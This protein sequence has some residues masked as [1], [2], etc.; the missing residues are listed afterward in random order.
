MKKYSWLKDSIIQIIFISFAV[1]FTVF[2]AQISLS[3]QYIDYYESKVEAKAQSLVHS[4][5]LLFTENTDIRNAAGISAVLDMIFASEDEDNL[6]IISYTL[7]EP[8]GR[9]TASNTANAPNLPED[10][11]RAVFR[12]H[13]AYTYSEASLA[14]SF[15]PMVIEGSVRFI[16]MVQIDDAPF[17][18]YSEELTGNLYSSLIRGTLMMAVGYMFFSVITN[19]RKNKK[20]KSEAVESVSAKSADDAIDGKKT[21]RDLQKIKEARLQMLVQCISL[22]IFAALAL[23]ALHINNTS[24]GFINTIAL[25]AA[26]LFSA[27][28][29]LHI[30]RIL[31]WVFAWYSKRPISSYAAQTM[32]FF[33]FLVV[34]LTM[35]VYTIQSGYST[36][37]DL[38][39]Q[40]ELRISSTFS[41][42]SLSGKDDI[43][44]V[45][46]Q[47]LG[48]DAGENN[49]L[50]IIT[51]TGDSF[52]VLGDETKQ[53]PEAN[54]LF[55]S[56]WEGQMSVTG[57]R[58]DYKYGITF[59]ADSDFNISALAAVRQ[60]DTILAD[61][62]QG[63]TIDF[64]LA[65]SATVFAF[66]FLFTELNRILETINLPNTKRE[67]ELRYAGG[68]RSLMF[69][70][71]ACRYIPLYY[72]VL[73]VRDI[74]EHNP[75]S[76]LPGELATVLPIAI[77]LIVMA[78]GRDI[79]GK[80]I[81]IKARKLMM[82]GCFIGF[83][84]FLI[85]NTA[86]TL[87]ALL[88]LLTITYTGLSMVYN[89]LWDYAQSVAGT[90]FE[91]FSDIKEQTLSGEFLG[92]TTGAVIGAL[93]Y[94]KLG[95]FAAFALSS[96]ILA[97]LM[98]FIRTMM[99][100]GEKIVK[101]EKS[102]LGFFRFFFSGRVL[103][104]ML[105]LLL[106][107]VIGEYFIE[108]FSPLYATSID[109]S[110]GAAS[111][112]SL[113]MTMTLA[114]IAPPF[115]RLFTGRISK[116]KICL[117]ANVLAAGGLMLF[118]FMPGLITMYATS[119]IIG[120][121][122]GIGKNIFAARYAELPETGMYANSGS[123]YNLFDSIFGLLGAAVFTLAYI[124]YF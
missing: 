27:V 18:Q 78:I 52:Y 43:E 106:P 75:I 99:P 120:V 80:L 23:I 97:I 89:G 73:I 26:I 30:L 102:E 111:W 65:M 74:Y 92:G 9:I 6:A 32:Q 49:D 87:P 34:F 79:A 38:M 46:K 93:V 15:H 82:L 33:L 117:F 17:M 55:F 67:R 29:V 48:L 13:A 76:W 104:F 37:I 71:N 64:L 14:R 72:F 3:E 12:E 19:L 83:S 58:G 118:A 123:V 109:L 31:L 16:L 121:S 95:L 108:Q 45:Q 21:P 112:T 5:A 63:K 86:T 40:N 103:I 57:I 8:D 2:I 90:G 39:T 68:T 22:I 100:Q 60:P 54:D 66:V 42:L 105:I 107:F 114:Y 88:L 61:E 53:I 25:S 119:A 44:E 41:A 51:R 59:I 24:D 69:L 11:M 84:G 10:V 122:I 20:K 50:L 94:D 1:I 36:Q 35:Y 116:T 47:S 96:V 115:V 91:E 77:V 62:M 81:R 110:P 70:A 4:S 113:I 85:L 56:A 124:F 28:A 7:F 98:I 101:K